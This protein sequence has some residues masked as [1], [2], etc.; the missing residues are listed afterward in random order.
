MRKLFVVVF[1]V[2]VAMLMGQSVAFGTS[3][4]VGPVQPVRRR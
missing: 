2:S 1:V 3:T 4:P